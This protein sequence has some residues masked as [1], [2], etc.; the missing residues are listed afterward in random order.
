LEAGPPGY[1]K[2][3]NLPPV[4]QASLPVEINPR[5]RLAKMTSDDLDELR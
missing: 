4:G 2:D 3:R 1:T 5:A